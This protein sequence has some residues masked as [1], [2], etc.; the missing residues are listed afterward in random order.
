[1]K[2]LQLET[3]NELLLLCRRMCYARF[4]KLQF[5]T[6]MPHYKRLI[7]TPSSCLQLEVC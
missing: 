5:V 3:I 4:F 7:S 1:M 2:V 6:W